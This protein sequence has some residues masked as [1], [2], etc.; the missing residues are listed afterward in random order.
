M[1][2]TS[3]AARAATQS[4]YDSVSE[5]LGTQLDSQQTTQF[6]D[7]SGLNTI[8]PDPITHAK[9]A[10]YL[11]SKVHSIPDHLA[12][13][14]LIDSV[15]LTTSSTGEV[16]TESVPGVAYTQ[17]V[18]CKLRNFRFFRA[19]VH[20]RVVCNASVYA[21]GRL[22]I[23]FNPYP[24]Q[25][26]DGINPSLTR[27]SQFPGIEM[28]FGTGTSV[29]FVVP[30]I[31]PYE[32]LDQQTDFQN[33]G[34]VKGY[35]MNSLTG[36][37]S[38]ETCELSIYEWFTDVDAGIPGPYPTAMSADE[39]E[40]RARTGVIS[41]SLATVAR[42]SSW[43]QDVP[44]LG[45]FAR[46]LS[47]FANLSSRTAASFGY[48]KPQNLVPHYTISNT[49]AFGFCNTNSTDTSVCLALEP[50]NAV[51][52]DPQFF[53]T[54]EDAMI[55]NRF[56]A[57]MAFIQTIDYSTSSAVDDVVATFAVSLNHVD[58][59]ASLCRAISAYWRGSI[60]VR[61]S[62]VKNAFYSGRLAFEYTSGNVYSP[63]YVPIL[64]KI[65][66]VR[67]NTE[68]VF[69]VPF[70]NSTP[71]LTYPDKLGTI[72][73]RVVS[74][75]KTIPNLPSTIRI[76]VWQACGPDFA[77]AWFCD[78][79]ALPTYGPAL[80]FETSELARR[81]S[82]LK[83]AALK[84]KEEEE[85][86][87][88]VLE[89]HS[90]AEPATKTGA[91][92]E[93]SAKPTTSLTAIPAFGAREGLGKALSFLEVPPT[94]Y[95]SETETIGEAF[96]SFKQA[97]L[98]PTYLFTWNVLTAGGAITVDP[99][100]VGNNSSTNVFWLI[101]SSFRFSRGSVR[102]KVFTGTRGTRASGIPLPN[103]RVFS[104]I[105]PTTAAIADVY[106]TALNIVSGAIHVT[107]LDINPVHEIMVPYF[108]NNRISVIGADTALSYHPVVN[109][110]CVWDDPV[111]GDIPPIFNVFV[112][113]G[114]DFSVGFQTAVPVMSFTTRT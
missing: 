5:Y 46:A 91:G 83:H 7:A 54:T 76:N 94:S 75:L 68:I 65:L 85:P 24:Q 37:D 53:A 35:L 16:F 77:P 41:S 40:D 56:C 88:E 66:D 31:S 27:R 58:I 18:E 101:C 17:M 49:P 50:Q 81:A 112:S 28:D 107:Y 45:P 104:A 60:I 102:Y 74:P 61:F 1:Q 100:Y 12:R 80:E 57:K 96:T 38:G 64:R 2:K 26:Y 43:F 93:T 52:V 105:R 30:F 6:L 39:G 9:P 111:I 73:L 23:Y 79:N 55:I 51:V 63:S 48:S 20:F 67:T 72:A 97:L 99:S 110:S 44:D 84:D 11:E 29:E 14:Q 108:H 34:V 33:F 13:P 42:V 3:P 98:R 21:Q 103:V 92:V 59:P 86:D 113:A 32:Y 95:Q 106:P 78:N 82:K 87:F 25:K 10:T 15:T 114:D 19:N 8:M 47:W 4:M 89:C 22:W 69:R 90:A 109:F 71:W 36:V 62:F 70:V